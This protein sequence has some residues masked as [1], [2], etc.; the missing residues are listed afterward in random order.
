[1]TLSY[2]LWVNGE[3]EGE[4]EGK[5]EREHEYENILIQQEEFWGKK[6]WRPWTGGISDS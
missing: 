1:M 6:A 2:L 3:R 5:D 4:G